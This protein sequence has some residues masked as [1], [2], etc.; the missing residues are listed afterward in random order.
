VDRRP[1][2]G[3]ERPL[4]RV[5]RR[6]LQQAVMQALQRKWDP[7]FSEHSYGFRPNPS[8]HQGVDLFNI[9]MVLIHPTFPPLP[10][11]GIENDS[12]LSSVTAWNGLGDLGMRL[13]RELTDSSLAN[14]LV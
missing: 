13:S 9:H 11:T 2:R 12:Q 7:T 1:L 8:A 3:G 6:L 5:E 10:E 14:D 4:L